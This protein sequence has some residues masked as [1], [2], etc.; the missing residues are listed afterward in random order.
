[1]AGTHI[2]STVNDAQARA[3]LA[4]LG[5]PGTD[6]LM[7]R[8]G[9]YLQASTQKRFKVQTA[10]DGTAWQPLQ[11]RYARRKKYAKDKVLTLRGYLRSGIHY[12][13]TGDAEVEVGSNTKYA[14]I[15]QFG[16]EIDMPERQASVRYRSVAGRTLFA[17]KKHKRVTEKTVT[18]P[19]H[20]VKIPARPFLGI[21][22]AD[23]SEIRDIVLNWVV[24]RSK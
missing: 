23:D 14:A 12:Q 22:T 6:D 15:H 4:R 19:V 21:S 10:P 11:P 13:V 7:P 20:F 1:M 2:K 18:V 8:L 9:E 17:S 3:M 24:K 16:G 5:E